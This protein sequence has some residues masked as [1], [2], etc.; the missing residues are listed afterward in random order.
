[1]RTRAHIL[2][3]KKNEVEILKYEIWKCRDI[4]EVHY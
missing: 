4:D 3:F 1:V 2:W